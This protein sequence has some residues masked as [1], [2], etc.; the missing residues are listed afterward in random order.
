M[1]QSSASDRSDTWGGLIEMPQHQVIQVALLGIILGLVAW[2]GSVV[3]KQAILTPLFCGDPTNGV[4]I[5]ATNVAGNASAVVVAF[6]GLMGL[7][8][9]SVYRPLLIALAVLISLWGIGGWTNGLEWYEAIAWFIA[10]YTF[11]YLAFSWLVRP[12]SFAPTIIL[13]LVAVAAIRFLPML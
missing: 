5:N 8:R 3:I 12:R 2:I 13:V 7:V 1:A 6:F 4:C 9:L 11:C 10:L